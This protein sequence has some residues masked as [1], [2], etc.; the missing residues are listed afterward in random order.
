MCHILWH[1]DENVVVRQLVLIATE[2]LLVEWEG[3]ALLAIDLEVLHLLAGFVELFWILDVDHSGAEWSG[4]VPLNLRLGVKDNSG[5]LLE[6]LGDQVASD[7]FLGKVVEVD[8][9]L[10]FHCK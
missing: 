3:T 8:K 1:F 2:E 4:E 7:I 6:N 5:F 9:L 10:W